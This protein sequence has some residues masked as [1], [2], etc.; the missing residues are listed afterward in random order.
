MKLTNK[1]IEEKLLPASGAFE[2]LFS[3]GFEEAED[4]CGQETQLKHFVL[5]LQA[6]AAIGG[7]HQVCSTVSGG[8][9]SSEE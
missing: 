5:L 9:Q 2:I 6:V 1:T 7:R 3:V 4:R 8:H